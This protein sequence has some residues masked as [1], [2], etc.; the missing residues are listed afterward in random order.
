M[1]IKTALLLEEKKQKL[2]DLRRECMENPKAKKI[3]SAF[4]KL[5]KEIKEL[6]NEY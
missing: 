5:Q 6:E 2:E 4:V 3:E 1:E